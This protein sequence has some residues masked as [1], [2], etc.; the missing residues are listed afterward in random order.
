MRYPHSYSGS[1]LVD[2]SPELSLRAAYD[3]AD[4]ALWRRAVADAR[5]LDVADACAR[6]GRETVRAELGMASIS[7]ID[8]AIRAARDCRDD[9]ERLTLALAVRPAIMRAALIAAAP[10][11]RVEPD[12]G[13]V[14][15]YYDA[16]GRDVTDEPGAAPVYRRAVRVDVGAYIWGVARVDLIPKQGMVIDGEA[17]N[18][19]AAIR[20]VLA[21]PLD[22]A[23][24]AI[25]DRRGNPT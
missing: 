21:E 25:P 1:M 7:G 23:P 3:A 20:R 18:P 24:T 22:S 14:A 4:P 12:T 8:K 11:W 17:D 2:E 16:D 13:T 5:A 9:P 15:R 6:R 19:V 10:S